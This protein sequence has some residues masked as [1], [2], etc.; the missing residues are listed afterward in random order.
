MRYR[1]LGRRRWPHQGT[2]LITGQQSFCLQRVDRRDKLVLL[3]TVLHL[4]PLGDF[5][6]R[7]KLFLIASGRLK[8]R[9]DSLLVVLPHL[10]SRELD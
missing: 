5:K 7:Q 6:R 8:L 2:R 9:E 4:L 1:N 10:F 3:A